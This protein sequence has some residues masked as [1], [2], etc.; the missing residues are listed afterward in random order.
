MSEQHD[1]RLPLLTP[2][3]LDDEQRALYETIVGGP[4]ASRAPAFPLTDDAGRLAGPFNAMLYSPTVGRPL[5]DLG[6]ALRFRTGFSKREREIAILVVAAGRRS[7][8]EWYAH[9]LIGRRAGLADHEIAALRRGEVPELSDPREVV[10]HRVAR[11]L[12]ERRDLDD[13]RYA[14]AAGTLGPATLVELI[15]LVGYYEALALQLRVLRVTVPEGEPV[16]HW[17]DDENAK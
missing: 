8:F 16:P 2:D 6:A 17:A 9:E 12:V 15:T 14:E 11:A 1:R 13:A 4:R 10:V 7:D 3:Q 5:Q